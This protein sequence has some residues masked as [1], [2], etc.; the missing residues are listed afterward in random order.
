[1]LRSLHQYL[2]TGENRR[3]S[4]AT[5]IVLFT[6]GFYQWNTDPDACGGDP[7]AATRRNSPLLFVSL[8][9]SKPK[10]PAAPVEIPTPES[11]NVVSGSPPVATIPTS[12]P[13]GPACEELQSPEGTIL[14]GRWAL[15]AS[16]YRLQQ[17]RE[18]LE[19]TADYS[20]QFRRQERVNGELLDAEAMHMKVRHEPFSYYMKWTEGDR[21]RQLIYVKGQNDDKVLVQPGG[22]AG[23]LTGALA[24]AP[25]D[26]R[27]MAVSRHPA[28]CAGLLEMTK[29]ILVCHESYLQ[30]AT[31]VSC[32]MRD[33][34]SF[35]NR[36][37]FLTTLVYDNPTI[38][39]DCY[40]SL[41]FIDKELSLPVSVRN[42]TWI[43]GQAPA[44]DDEDSLLEHYSF[45]ELQINTQL[46]DDDFTK[47]KYRMR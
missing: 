30:L 46:S 13:A 6:L 32:E 10:H 37:C 20:A 14:T 42:Y 41:I 43:D 15:K 28:N 38:N 8:D 12:T 19:K 1:M 35:D 34:E 44:T 23:R 45:T 33:G 26:A 29:F 11:Q 27:I 2:L 16:Q 7:V 17:G 40:K 3:N 5:L 47:Q 31:G 39:P 36:P 25:D 24:L 18:L 22:V 21:G 9:L 4:Y